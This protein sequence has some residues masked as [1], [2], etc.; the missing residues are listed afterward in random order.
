MKK[1]KS[2]N[3]T[4]EAGQNLEMSAEDFEADF[5]EEHPKCELHFL[6]LPFMSLR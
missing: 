6:N 5:M 1:K 2:L 3:A 4:R